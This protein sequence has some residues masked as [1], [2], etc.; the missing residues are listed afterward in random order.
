MSVGELT[1]NRR[2][3]R[4]IL[5]FFGKVK[6]ETFN[7]YIYIYT[8]NYIYIYMHRWIYDVFDITILWDIMRYYEILGGDEM[9]S[10]WYFA[11]QILSPK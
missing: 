7:I 1:V 11:G 6:L 4:L 2:R 10:P 9:V 8:Y 5:F 3:G